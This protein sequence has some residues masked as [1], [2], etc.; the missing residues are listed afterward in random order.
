MLVQQERNDMQRHVQDIW[1]LLRVHANIKN[2]LEELGRSPCRRVMPTW[3]SGNHGRSREPSHTAAPTGDGG[4]EEVLVEE[5]C[6]LG[7]VK[8]MGRMESLHVPIHCNE[9]SVKCITYR[10]ELHKI[11]M[12]LSSSNKKRTQ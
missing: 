2:S 9:Y 3:R 10:D 11:I 8:T 6:R 12:K 7:G 4:V 5:S 1:P